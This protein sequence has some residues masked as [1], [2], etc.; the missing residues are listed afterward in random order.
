MQIQDVW[1]VR[2]I[3]WI[4]ETPRGFGVYWLHSTIHVF[5]SSETLTHCMGSRPLCF[6]CFGHVLAY[7]VHSLEAKFFFFQTTDR[8]QLMSGPGL[9]VGWT[10][11]VYL[12][13][14]NIY[15]QSVQTCNEYS[16]LEI[17]SFLT[18]FEWCELDVVSWHITYIPCGFMVCIKM[19]PDKKCI[20]E[21]YT[22]RHLF[23][24]F[25]NP[26]RFGSGQSLCEITC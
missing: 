8:V 21:T 20:F 22:I 1:C 5:V 6:A 15:L 11:L 3:L 24:G 2:Y 25:E 10:R 26:F 17:F 14:D 12:N 16:S 9:V 23:C 19:C 4:D 18:D 7:N 13:I